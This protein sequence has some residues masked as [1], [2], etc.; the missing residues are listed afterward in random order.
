MTHEDSL[1]T[2]ASERASTYFYARP[3]IAVT[4]L[5]QATRLLWVRPA[6]IMATGAEDFDRSFDYFATHQGGKE[7]SFQD[8]FADQTFVET[9]L[10]EFSAAESSFA[11]DDMGKHLS[12]QPVETTTVRVAVHEQLAALYDDFAQEGAMTVTG[13][14]H[15]KA[16]A[17]TPFSVLLRDKEQNVQSF[18]VA[19]VVSEC[20][21]DATGGRELIVELQESQLNH[22]I[23]IAS[24][25]CA[26]ELR[27][28]PLVSPLLPTEYV[29]WRVD[30]IFGRLLILLASVLSSFS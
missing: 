30:S 6:F 26:P 3:G 4:I 24:Y 7:D 27:P 5:N 21:L 8:E 15:V 18:E 13:S 2:F 19:G 11:E 28:V 14:I 9:D 29:L 1:F 10:F 12:E 22:D 23:P 25:V 20:K 17:V 16:A